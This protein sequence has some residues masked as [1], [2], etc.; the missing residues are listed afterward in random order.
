M[1]AIFDATAAARAVAP[2]RSEIEFLHAWSAFHLADTT[3]VPSTHR[4]DAEYRIDVDESAVL[5]VLDR[6]AA[7]APGDPLFGEARRV[8]AGRSSR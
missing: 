7:L 5:E 2:A 6:G 8:V 4:W 3:G 1:R